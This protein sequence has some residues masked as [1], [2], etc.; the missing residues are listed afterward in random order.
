MLRLV[1]G[2]LSPASKS[3]AARRAPLILL[4]CLIAGSALAQPEPLT[5]AEAERLALAANPSLAANAAQAEALAAVP[6]QRGALPD[7]VLGFNAMNLPTDTFNLDQEPMTQVQVAIT[8]SLPFPGKLS[9]R[10][11]AA[12]REAAAASQQLA[13]VRLTLRARVRERWWRLFAIDRSL[14][15]V[16][17]NQDLTR[18]FVEVAQAKYTVGSGLQQDVL[19]AQL[20]LSRLLDRELRL[21]GRREAV[22]AELNAL[23]NRPA[24][25]AVTLPVQPPNA[26]LPE[27]PAVSDLLDEAVDSRPLLAR[28]RELLAAARD[29]VDLAKRDYYPDFRLGAAYGFRDARD[30][31]SGK[32]LPDFL[33]LM[34]SFSVP[35]HAGSR[36]SK[37]VEQRSSEL[38]RQRALLGD[39]LRSVEAEISASHARYRSAREQA[40]LFQQ[41]ILPQARQTVESMLAGYQVDEVDFL[42]VVNAELR[43][44]DAQIGYWDAL[45]AAKQALAGLAA[46]TGREDLYE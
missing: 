44:F 40:R 1:Q 41:G 43:L 42:N 34:F 18:G 24:A 36:Q 37:A 26:S 30:R 12:E 25:N 13:E 5:L 3:P 33:S 14:E 31:V 16:R 21:R 29:R 45:A 9:L 6:S 17:D 27:L 39:A 22:A 46:A 28:Q 38:G 4:L 19:L 8:Q 10:R 2:R 15:I 20:E 11:A 7:P 23:L 35:I 32:T